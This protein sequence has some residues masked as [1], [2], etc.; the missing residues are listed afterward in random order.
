VMAVP[1][2]ARDQV[3]ASAQSLVGEDADPLHAHRTQRAR[4]GAEPAAELFGFSLP[5]PG[6]FRGIQLMIAAQQ[7]Q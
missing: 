3:A 5:G 6:K 1:I 2:G 4:V 7:H